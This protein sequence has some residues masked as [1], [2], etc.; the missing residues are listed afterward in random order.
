MQKEFPAKRTNKEDG[1]M[2]H[3]RYIG[4]ENADTRFHD[5]ALRPVIGAQNIQVMRANREH[6]EQSQG[7]DFTYNHAP[8]LCRWRH[9]LYL[10]YLTSPVHEHDGLGRVMLTES[11]DGYTW[12]FPRLLF[13]EIPVPMGVYRG[14]GAEALDANAKTVV[15]HRMGFYLAPNGVL[16]AMTFH[17]VSPDI[18]IAP[19]SGW[20]MGRVA[21]RILEDGSLGEIFVLRINEKAGWKKEHFP[22][23][24]FEESEDADFVSA[25]RLLL[26]DRLANGAWWEEERLDENFFPL[27]NIK[28]P[29]FCPLPDGT[30]GVIGK[31]GLTALSTD[32]G[33]T[34]TEPERMDNIFTSMGKCA[35][36]QTGDGH[37]AIVCNPSPDGQHRWP[38]AAMVS[39]DGHTYDHLCCVCGEVPPMRYG[40][41]MKDFG[42]Q[43]IRGIMPG[44]DD[45]P[46]GYT[47]LAY[48]MNKEDIW[49]VRLPAALAWRETQPV[50]ERFSHMA[51]PFPERWHL[52]APQWARVGIENGCLTL[53]DSD[54]CD[55]AKAIRVFPERE[56]VQIHL[57][58]SAEGLEN[59]ELHLEV[60]DGKGM[61]AL[62]L[63]LRPDGKI[64]LRGGS[65]QWPVAEYQNGETLDIL[66][67]IDCQRKRISAAV[68]GQDSGDFMPIS[69]CRTVERLTLRTGPLRREPTIDTELKGVRLPDIQGAGERL[70]EA[71]YRLDQL[72]IIP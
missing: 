6:P 53:H 59:G 8:M 31:M 61:N 69:P 71:V 66:L 41:F 40:G 5:G 49:V 23:R 32:G 33:N 48:S 68:N 67:N 24:F 20:G 60:S 17:G 46:D 34:W 30:V 29:S 28:A 63:M 37:F 51:G 1:K 55:Y 39:E 2:A 56:A 16:L 57:L 12:S 52:Y 64:V 58:L 38:L 15:H 7:I 72:D 70:D 25:C 19:N 9:K 45:F 18:H 14:K 62:R 35:L 47:W 21:R 65:G 43:Y 11:A 44:N 3:F 13:P 26:S 54:P 50:H 36:L 10:M 22:Y 42:P 27:K 4:E